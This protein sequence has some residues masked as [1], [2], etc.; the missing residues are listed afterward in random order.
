M[1]HPVGIK[2]PNDWGLYDMSG[3]VMEAC[4]DWYDEKFY[5]TPQ[6]K[7]NNPCNDG[8]NA[9]GRRTYRVLRGGSWVSKS[10]SC[11]SASRG[12]SSPVNSFFGNGFR[13]VWTSESEELKEP[14][15]ITG[16]INTKESKKSNETEKNLKPSYS[17]SYKRR[18]QFKQ[19]TNGAVN[20]IGME[21]VL[22]KPG[23]FMMGSPIDESG[24]LDKETLH[25]VTLSKAFYMQTTEVTQ[26]Q[27]KAVMGADNNPSYHKENDHP[28]EN[29]SWNTAQE[30][31]KKLNKKERKGK[32]RLPTE[33]E[34][35]YACRAGT[36]STFYWGTLKPEEYSWSLSNS[37]NKTNS[38]GTKKPNG[39]G[40]YD[41]SGNIL[42]WCKDWYDK[43]F[44]D[45][46]EAMKD[47]CN[48]S[49]GEKNYRIMRGGSYGDGW[50]YGRSAF[51]FNFYP[52]VRAKILRFSSCADF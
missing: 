25:Q 42:E 12:G 36:D 14:D 20:S 22:I 35:E 46:A 29:V 50:G 45:R 10:V 23:I 33:A 2:K 44:Y 13:I 8:E 51:R 38:V 27:W 1:T 34:W 52:N 16:A 4:Q 15:S 19:T 32:Y 30:F 26:A 40:L 17:L 7:E 48:E 3:N 41:M 18:G 6:A 43:G 31:I 47:P 28:V 49:F 11:R 5:E 9:T 39:W 21:F 37:G 24:R